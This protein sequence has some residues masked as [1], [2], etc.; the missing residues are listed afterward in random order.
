M[1][2][3]FEKVD[4]K[5]EKKFNPFFKTVKKY[6][7]I[8]SATI[9]GLL[10]IF[11]VLRVIH[12]KKYFSTDIIV[13]E[14]K[15]ISIALK[16]ID[17]DC[18]ILSVDEDKNNIDFLNVKSFE[19]SEVGSLNLAYPKKWKGPYLDDNPTFQNK[20]YQIIRAK[21]GY[22]V[23]PGDGV[24]LPNG[25]TIGI[26]FKLSKDSEI[27][28]MLKKG[29]KL[30]YKGVP[31]GIKLKFEIGDWGKL[32]LKEKEMKEISSSIEEFNEAMPFAYNQTAPYNC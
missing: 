6:F 1:K 31:L 32:D 27:S 13:S 12:D 8:F 9:L 23:A 7:S 20:A 3:L 28:K 21:D 24:K 5:V 25:F 15:N 22:F 14:L 11:F 29:G 17:K 30:N 10:V 26:D 19:G 18:S 16:K 2:N 4:E